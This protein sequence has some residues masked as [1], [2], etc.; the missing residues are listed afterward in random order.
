MLAQSPDAADFVL[1]SVTVTAT[2]S[3]W[4]VQ[5][6]RAGPVRR[7]PNFA[8]LEVHRLTGRT[9]RHRVR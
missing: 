4:L 5:I 1:D 7:V 8:L 9:M 6:A 2:D 3:S